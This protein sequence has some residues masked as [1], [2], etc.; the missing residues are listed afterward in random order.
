MF[1]PSG[2][3]PDASAYTY[4]STPSLAVMVRLYGAPKAPIGRL[5]GSTIIT[6]QF[7]GVTLME[8]GGSET[9]S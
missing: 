6:G 2:N 4:G 7:W 8:K 3:A 5:A 9:V 1:S